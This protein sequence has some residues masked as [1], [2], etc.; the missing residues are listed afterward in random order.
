MKQRPKKPPTHPLKREI[1][2]DLRVGINVA[3][4]ATMIDAISGEK[5]HGWV[6]NLSRGGLYVDCKDGFPQ[7]T[8]ITVDALVR[9][10]DRAYH[11]KLPGWV[12]HAGAY[13]MGIQ[14]D[15]LDE[16]TNSVVVSLIKQALNGLLDSLQKEDDS[17]FRLNLTK[18]EPD[19]PERELGVQINARDPRVFG[20]V[21]GLVQQ[22]LEDVESG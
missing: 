9:E 10:G 13:G 7:N 2:A 4:R 18:W 16:E 1:R 17:I 12:A 3:I 20:A 5:L 14:F 21:Q 19:A 6:R 11:L 8:N 15:D 22:A